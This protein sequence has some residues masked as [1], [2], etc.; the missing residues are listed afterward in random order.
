MAKHTILIADDDMVFLKIMATHCHR[1]GLEIRVAANATNALIRIKENPPDLILLD[2]NMPPGNG[3]TVCEQLHHDKH[4]C[5]IPIIVLTG[6]VD[7]DAKHRCSE[8]GVTYV[9]KSPF[10]WKEL[11]PIFYSLLESAPSVHHD[12]QS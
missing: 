5:H 9:L 12:N 1:V 6:T 4:L 8:L 10:V 2:I 3:L 11:E 7:D